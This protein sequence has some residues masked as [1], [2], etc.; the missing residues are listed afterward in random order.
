MWLTFSFDILFPAC[1]RLFHKC[2]H[3]Q[4]IKYANYIINYCNLVSTVP[5]RRIKARQFPQQSARN[6][7]HLGFFG[8]YP[9]LPIWTRF[10]FKARIEIRNPPEQLGNS[11]Q[12]ESIDNSAASTRTRWIQVWDFYRFFYK[13]YRLFNLSIFFR[14]SPPL[15]DLCLIARALILSKLHIN[16]QM[17]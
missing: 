11:Y 16:Q 5:L 6:E 8:L 15:Q 4:V 14:Y 3:Q 1:T 9:H 2:A 13:Y 10:H 12:R 7:P 17:I